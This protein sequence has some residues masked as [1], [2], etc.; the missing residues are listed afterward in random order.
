DEVAGCKD[1][2]WQNGDLDYDG[3]PYWKEWPT[4][5][6]INQATSKFPLSF[7]ESPPQTAGHQYTQ[8]RFQTDVALTEST[9]QPRNSTTG[10]KVPPPNAPGKFYPYWSELNSSGKC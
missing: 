2:W 6:T 1:S 5:V 10:C 3:S 7:V 4:S 8:Y 9:C